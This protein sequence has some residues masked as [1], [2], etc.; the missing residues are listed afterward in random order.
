MTDFLESS[1]GS[2]VF[3]GRFDARICAEFRRKRMA[4]GLSYCALGRFLGVHWS[5]I[6]KWENGRICHCSI[7]FQKRIAGF[8]R[9][10]FDYDIQA[11]LGDPRLGAYLRPVSLGAMA[12]VQHFASCYHLLESR[13]DL[14]SLL[15]DEAFRA[16]R[17]ALLEIKAELAEP[18]SGK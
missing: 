15:L 14:R 1:A 17:E 12:C 10:D 5:T 4:L 3:Q 16:A 11:S 9:G 7:H 2:P 18:S 6:R 13:P 8:L